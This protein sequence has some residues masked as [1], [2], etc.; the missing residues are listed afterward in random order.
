MMVLTG[1]EAYS[2]SNFG[3]GADPGHH[4]H[5][6]PSTRVPTEAQVTIIGAQVDRPACPAAWTVGVEPWRPGD[7]RGTNGGRPQGKAP[8]PA[9]DEKSA[10][11]PQGI[12]VKGLPPDV[13]IWFGW[14]RNS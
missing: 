6:R 3:I 4:E 12:D 1:A 10:T 8:I 13:T 2:R 11:P 5:R 14:P 9:I 7:Q